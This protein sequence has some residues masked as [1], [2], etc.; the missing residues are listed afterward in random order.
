MV[1]GEQMEVSQGPD[2]VIVDQ[3]IEYEDYGAGKIMRSFKSVLGN[4]L[5]F[6]TKITGESITFEDLLSI[7]IKEI[8][9][10]ANSLVGQN[11]EKIVIG[12][13]VKFVLCYYSHHIGSF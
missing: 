1:T 6:V 13:P 7:F 12:R 10:R 2:K 9:A 3:V 5:N 4:S 11:V 8:K